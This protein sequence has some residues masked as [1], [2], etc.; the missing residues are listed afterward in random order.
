MG[1]GLFLLQMAGMSGAG[2]STLARMIADQTGALVVDYDVLKSAALDAGAVWDLAGRI[3][4]R[5]SRAMASSALQQGLSVILD[6]PCRFQQ[7]VDE[8]AAIAANWGASYAFVE[9]VLAD[10]SE[11]RR[12]LRT[13]LPQRSQRVAFDVPP[14]DAPSD[15]MLDTSG[16]IRILES[17]VPASPWLRVDTSQ[18]RDGCIS[19][20]LAYLERLCSTS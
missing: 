16:T 4:Y 6:S 8:G 19:T 7:I 5:A 13:R 2:K 3:G 20:A 9:C 17:K 14:P 1:L 18:P 12:R 15:P 11:L 10:E